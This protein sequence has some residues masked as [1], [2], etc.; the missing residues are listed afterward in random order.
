METHRVKEHLEGVHHEKH[1]HD[2][3]H[4]AEAQNEE[5]DGGND[6]AH[7]FNSIKGLEL[8]EEDRK[9]HFTEL[10]VSQRQSPKTQVGGRV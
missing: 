6:A 1:T 7:V 2:C 10:T 8:S 3:E 4:E 9:E 5:V